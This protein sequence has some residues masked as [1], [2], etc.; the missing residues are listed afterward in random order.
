MTKSRITAAVPSQPLPAGLYDE[1]LSFNF[2]HLD[3]FMRAGSEVAEGLNAINGEILNLTRSQ[4]EKSIAAGTRL[5]ECRSPDD[6][7]G[8]QYGVAAGFYEDCF[9][10]TRRILDTAQHIVS[11]T[12]QSI[13]S[14]DGTR[15]EGSAADG[16]AAKAG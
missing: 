2:K 1:M 8:W 11:A 5:L 7:I 10:A 13:A 14:A 12:A 3:G 9:A 15:D 6:L 16:S 4:F